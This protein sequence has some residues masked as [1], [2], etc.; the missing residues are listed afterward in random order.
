MLN[1]ASPSRSSSS[2]A[3]V[4]MR[5]RVNWR[6]PTG[7]PVQC[8]VRRTGSTREVLGM[9]VRGLLT[10]AALALLAPATAAAAD[11]A[12]FLLDMG[13]RAPGAG[14]ALRF[15]VVFRHPDDP[16]AK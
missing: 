9:M 10:G 8:T 2:S 6:A 11:R 16:N 3:V 12:D 7:I 13:T 15:D 1:P 4:A 14:A 5:S